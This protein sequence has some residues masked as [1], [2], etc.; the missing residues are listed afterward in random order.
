M[1]TGNISVISSPFGLKS[2]SICCPQAG[3][4]AGSIAEKN[5]HGFR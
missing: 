5:L 3:L 1:I 4:T 2:F